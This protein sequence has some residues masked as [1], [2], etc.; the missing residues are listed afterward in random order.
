M[1]LLMAPPPRSGGKQ[2]GL[3]ERPTRPKLFGGGSS[4]PLVHHRAILGSGMSPA[5][6]GNWDDS[7]DE[8]KNFGF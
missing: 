5:D 2:G 4:T 1:G 7:V 8:S 6:E 3:D